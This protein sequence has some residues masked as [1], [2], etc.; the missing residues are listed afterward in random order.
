MNTLSHYIEYNSKLRV[1][2]SNLAC[3]WCF[4]GSYLFNC[5]L[6][7]GKKKTILHFDDGPQVL[8]EE[9]LLLH[10]LCCFR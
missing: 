10:D 7:I 1:H 6:S 3:M 2:K 5:W 4:K 8:T 9:A